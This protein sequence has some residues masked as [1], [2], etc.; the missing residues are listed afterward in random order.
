[1]ATLPVTIPVSREFSSRERLEDHL[2]LMRK[3]KCILDDVE[4]PSGQTRRFPPLPPGISGQKEEARW[5][6]QCLLMSAEVRYSIYLQILERWIYGLTYS[7]RDVAI[8]FYAH[9]L[10]PFNFQRD[11]GSNFPNLWKAEIEFPLARMRST[12]TDE[13]S[14]RA[15]TR[16]YPDVSYQVV[17]FIPAGDHAYITADDAMDIHGYN[18]GW[19]RCATNATKGEC[20]IRMTEWPKYRVGRAIIICPRCQT[21]MFIGKTV[22]APGVLKFSR[23]AFGFPIFDLW[24]SPQR[25]FGS[26][27]FVDRI[28]ALTKA[29]GLLPDHVSRYLKFLQLIKESKSTLVPTLDIDLLWHTHQLSPVAYEKYCKKY[30]R[31]QI[32]HVDTIRATTRST[33]QDDTERLWATRYGE[34]YFDPESTST[35]TEIKRRKARWKGKREDWG[36]KLAPYDHNH[37]DLKKGREEA[38]DRASTKRTGIRIARKAARVLHAALL[39]LRY[40]RQSQ[41]QQLRELEYNRQ[42]LMEERTYK[43]R[44]VETLGGE[45]RSVLREQERLNKKWEEAEKRRQVLEQRLTTEVALPTV[46]IWPFNVDGTDRHDHQHQ[47][48]QQYQEDRYNGSWYSIVP[49]EVQSDVHPIVDGVDDRTSNEEGVV[50]QED[51]ASEEV[52]DAAAEEGVEVADAVVV[53]ACNNNGECRDK[54]LST[55]ATSILELI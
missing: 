16:E 41:G 24:D 26:Q 21:E 19:T 18:C 33:G 7:G 47:H 23:A 38:N 51:A 46:A 20:V 43:W 5:R 29:R 28:L 37:Q 48:Q 2:E 52:A 53:K 50:Q 8:I 32:N 31:R 39:K 17:E 36:A 3:F 44:E 49:S 40:Y 14:K 11:V 25:Q 4:Q 10:S 42:S 9:L 27:G 30:L 1:M 55:S 22:E 6:V 34:S 54:P 45:G 35:S 12:N 15:W 13:A